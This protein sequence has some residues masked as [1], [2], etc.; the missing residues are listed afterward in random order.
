MEVVAL[1]GLGCAA[2]VGISAF[3]AWIT[4]LLWGVAVPYFFPHAPMNVQHPPFM[5]VWATT[6]LLTLLT[7]GVRFGGSKS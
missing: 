7:G 1:Y 3:F 5:V 4:Q 6:V 2:I